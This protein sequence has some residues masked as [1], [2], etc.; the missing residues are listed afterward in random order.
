MLERDRNFNLEESED[1]CGKLIKIE[2][3]ELNI[4]YE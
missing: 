4:D 2:D 1:D 3:L